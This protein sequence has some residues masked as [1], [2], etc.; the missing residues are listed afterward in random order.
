LQSEEKGH[1]HHHESSEQKSQSALHQPQKP[2]GSHDCPSYKWIG[3]IPSITLKSIESLQK[4]LQV[5]IMVP[6]VSGHSLDKHRTGVVAD[7]IH[8]HPPP[9]RAL[10]SILRI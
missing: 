1:C 9:H 3:S 5:A 4:N 7:D 6:G 8:F 2:G 10:S